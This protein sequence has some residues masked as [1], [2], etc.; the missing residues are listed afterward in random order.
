MF[1]KV[2]LGF[3][4]MGHTHEDINGCFGYLSKKLREQHNE[5]LANLVKPFMVL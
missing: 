1:K 5:I 4:V 2:K 3:L